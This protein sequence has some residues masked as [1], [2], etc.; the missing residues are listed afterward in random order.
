MKVNAKQ[1]FE[2][3]REVVRDELKKQL[4]AVVEKVLTER[5]LRGLIQE[6]SGSPPVQVGRGSLREML[7]IPAP[8]PPVRV[9]SAFLDRKVNPLADLYEGTSP[10]SDKA[11]DVDISG[12]DFS[13]MANLAG[14]LERRASIPSLP[15]AAPTLMTPAQKAAEIERMRRELDEK[16]V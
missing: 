12:L 2:T 8:P 16:K 14:A 9:N 6:S 13:R 4:P 10:P 7:D 5:Y 3:V 15:G 1:F 11:P